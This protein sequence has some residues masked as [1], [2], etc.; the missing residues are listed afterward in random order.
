MADI[1]QSPRVQP[2]YWGKFYSPL[3]VRIIESFLADIVTGTYMN[4]LAQYGIKRG[5]VLPL[6]RIADPEPNSLDDRGDKLEVQKKLL[7]W[8]NHDRVP[9]PA[10][11][12]ASL[13][14]LIMPPV[15]TELNPGD[16]GMQGYHTCFKFNDDS[17][18]PDVV[19]CILKTNDTDRTTIMKFLND[20]SVAQKISHELF[21]A[22]NDPFVNG[23][24]ELGDGLE[25]NVYLYKSK[26][27]VQQYLSA[28][29]NGIN[30]EQPISMKQFLFAIGKDPTVDGAVSSVGIKSFTTDAIADFM[31]DPNHLSELFRRS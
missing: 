8:L 1:I 21:E 18:R 16:N 6:V 4:N 19:Y 13:V 9:R 26:W 5:Q 12:E 29:P 30:G 3:V 24:Q 27:R 25:D 15:I 14:Y 31:A 22:F 23:R 10:V 11:N 7:D 28:W 17:A 2:I 20:S